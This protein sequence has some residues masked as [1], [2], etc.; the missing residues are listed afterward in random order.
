MPDVFRRVN[1]DS[2]DQVIDAIVEFAHSGGGSKSV[3]IGV[4]A[5]RTQR[6]SATIETFLDDAPIL[7]RI[8]H[9]QETHVDAMGLIERITRRLNTAIDTCVSQGLPP[10]LVDVL[11]RLILPR[12]R[13]A[14]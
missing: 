9:D 5:A 2:I 4:P 10:E 13:P 7:L 12:R 6:G 1:G 8:I 11:E 3:T 14:A